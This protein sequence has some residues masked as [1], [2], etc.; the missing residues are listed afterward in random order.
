MYKLRGQ[1]LFVFH[2]FDIDRHQFYSFEETSDFCRD[3]GLQMVPLISAG[4][5]LP[6][7]VEDLLKMADGPSILNEKA[8]REGLVLRSADRK[9]SFKAISNAFLEAED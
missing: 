9:I 5:Q 1:H 4:F 3:N 2:V 8:G 7:K 6:A